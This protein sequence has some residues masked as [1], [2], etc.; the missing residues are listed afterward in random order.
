MC[1]RGD[2]AASEDP[3]LL[4]AA[5]KPAPVEMRPRTAGVTSAVWVTSR[6]TIVIGTPLEKTI[7]A[8]SGST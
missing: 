3:E 1:L 5:A 4:K 2:A 8:A 6:G 7:A